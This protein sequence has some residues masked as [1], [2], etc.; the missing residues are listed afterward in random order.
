MGNFPQIDDPR[1]HAWARKLGRP[2]KE[3]TPFRDV[4]E[5]FLRWIYEL[6]D[7]QRASDAVR[8]REQAEKQAMLDRATVRVPGLFRPVRRE[9]D[10]LM[11]RVAAGWTRGR[12]GLRREAYDAVN[13]AVPL[14]RWLNSHGADVDVDR[15]TYMRHYFIALSGLGNMPVD[16]DELLA[17]VVHQER[18]YLEA[19]RKVR[20]AAAEAE[21]KVRD[22]AA[23]ASRPGLQREALLRW[24]RKLPMNPVDNFEP[25]IAFYDMESAGARKDFMDHGGSVEIDG[26]DVTVSYDDGKSLFFSSK[27]LDFRGDDIRTA[28]AA[29]VRR[30]KKSGRLV[31]FVVHQPDAPVYRDLPV[32]DALTQADRMYLGV[33]YLLTPLIHARFTRDPLYDVALG[34]LGVL[35]VMSLGKLLPVGAR[36]LS[37]GVSTTA[38]VGTGLFAAGRSAAAEV[39][40]AV[41]TYGF[42]TQAATWV[43]RSAWHY[44]LT[45]AV[46][47]NTHVIVGTEIAL[48]F[49]GQ[50]M[51]PLSLGDSLVMASQTDDAVRAGRRTWQEV[52]AQVEIVEDAGNVARLTV[53]K[54]EEI[55]ED[56][57]KREY[58]LGKK[59]VAAKPGASK[60]ARG[61]DDA[62][63]QAKGVAVPR[64]PVVPPGAVAKGKRTIKAPFGAIGPPV[65]LEDLNAAKATMVANL[66]RFPSVKTKYIPAALDAIRGISADAIKTAGIRAQD[67]ANLAN[68]LSRAG[69]S[70]RAFVNDY[71][72]VPGFEQVLLNWAK[73]AYWN[74]RGNKPS[75]VS[76]KASYTGATYVMKYVT[77]KKLPPLALRFEW[78]VSINDTRFGSEVTARWVDIVLS[79]GERLRPGATIQIEL[80]S[81]TEET[82]RN[83]TWSPPGL[84][85]AYPGTVGY[86]LIR[87]TALFRPENIRWVFDPSKGLTKPQV[88]RAFERVIAN[89]PYLALQWG[90]KD[91]SPRAIRD[92]L[93]KVIEVF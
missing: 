39:M 53:T 9:A 86:Q 23:R 11:A 50:D 38:R 83:K 43:G 72:A 37:A 45:N 19:E 67:L 63:T 33:P 20:D 46:A 1:F 25:G 7:E 68:G 41:R 57:A 10:D 27:I 93:D 26:Y 21:R 13:N 84:S 5:L 74:T 81:W 16:P 90:G 80:K 71:H 87:D 69:P 73:R 2:I 44:Y 56:V 62:A 6:G 51:G 35:R 34:I 89:D 17:Q 59:V 42:T 3:G 29:F 58:D 66:G 79:D 30:H 32:I 88:I 52:T 91:R 70:V 48:G 82:L 14:T 75:W 55:A 77:G 31:M 85:T 60:S 12:P 61:V 28:V 54:V 92:L 65:L 76:S 36:I 18:L 8:R 15:W 22:A 49:A 40:L 4:L 78:P 24:A 47:I 64:P